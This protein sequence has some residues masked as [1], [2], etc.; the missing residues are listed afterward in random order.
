MRHVL[1][2]D[3][4]PLFRE[5]LRTKLADNGVDASVA[6][7]GLDG[8][9]KIRTLVPD[10]IIMDYH[11][12]GERQNIFDIL[13]E[14][15]KN[16]NTAKIPVI[17]LAQRIDQKEIIELVPY[18]V[19]KV[20]AKP[21]KIDTLFTTL[22]ELLGVPFEVDETP[23]IMEAHVN[24]DII[25]VEIAQGLNRDK[26]DLLRFKI[27]ELIELYE[28]R[29]PKLIVMLSD[30]SFTFTDGPNLHKL[31]DT[32]LQSSRAKR[33]NVRVLTRDEFFK[34]FIAGQ[35][36]Y[37]NIEVVS[38]L[39]YA[40]D[41]LLSELDGSMEFGEKKAEIIGDRVL[42]AAQ[43]GQPESMQLRFDAENKNKHM[44]LE[45]VKDV[46][47]NLRI[48]AVDDDFVIQELIKNTFQKV[49]TS[50]SVFSDGSEYLSALQKEHFDLV[51]LDLMMPHTD[52]FEVLKVLRGRGL[53]QPV[54]VL[55]ALTQRDTVIKA[56]QMGIKSYMVKPLKPDDLLKKTM[57]I[58]RVNF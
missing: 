47:K 20:F 43:S 12:S 46:A 28:I 4:S 34:K 52:G 38:N 29:V 37:E 22:T 2:I 57:E 44:S 3:E 35:K 26:L 39:Q 41:G 50:V 48:A 53:E 14:K 30:I 16:P 6:V 11:L 25:F 54:I 5:Y 33:R 45:D 7:N 55:S 40:L 17:V 1:V 19:K 27:I 36:D 42:Q 18:N 58:L 32:V 31:L 8:T 9:A 21:I 51:F 23:S 15:K 56:F 24:D 10:L 49:G 13:R